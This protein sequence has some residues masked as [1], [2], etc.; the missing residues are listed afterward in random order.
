M[1]IE[2]DHLFVDNASP[3]A[4]AT[5]YVNT[6]DAWDDAFL[7][8]MHNDHDTD[9]EEFWR[10]T[11]EIGITRLKDPSQGE[12]GGRMMD[13]AKGIKL[14][15]GAAAQNREA[16]DQVRDVVKMVAK[17]TL[18]LDDPFVGLPLNRADRGAIIDV[19]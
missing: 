10:R 13:L 19:G 9:R 1:R 8:Q 6:F 17:E 15:W 11:D 3:K 18:G 4:G 14:G 12:A 7:L 5:S 16:I 2:E